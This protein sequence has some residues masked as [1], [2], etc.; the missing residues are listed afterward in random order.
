VGSV[1]GGITLLVAGGVLILWCRLGR[2][3]KTPTGHSIVKP[4]DGYPQS[5]ATSS[6]E[7]APRMHAF[8]TTMQ[9]LH[10]LPDSPPAYPQIA[11]HLEGSADSGRQ[12]AS[13]ASIASSSTFVT[14]A[15]K[16]ARAGLRYDVDKHN[17]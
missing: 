13:I 2:L 1:L 3:R 16:L 14:R 4:E 17:V 11:G 5:A 7:L 15:E 9:S 8:E 10:E 6:A 12:S